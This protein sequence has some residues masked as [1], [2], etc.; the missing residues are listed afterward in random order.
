MLGRTLGHYRIIEKIGAGGMGVVYRAHDEQ[1]ERDVA[2]KILPANLISD[3]AAQKRFRKEALA[4]AKLNHSNIATVF[5]FA[6]ADG[7]FF[8]AMEYI[9]GT[10]LADKIHNAALPEKEVV[11]LGAQIAAALE[12][13]HEHKVIH[14]DLKPRNIVIT[15]AGQAKVLDFGLA[16][17]LIPESDVSTADA[18]SPTGVI[19]GTLPYMAPEQ[20]RAQSP[21]AR[22]DIYA[23]GVMLYEMASG[24]LPYSDKSA[25]ALITDILQ[26][27]PP[28]PST[29]K[30]GISPRLEEIILKCLEKDPENRYQSAKEL[31][32]DLRRLANPTAIYTP[33]AP[34][35][36]SWTAARPLLIYGSITFVAACILSVALYSGKWRVHLDKNST[37]GNIQSIA[38]LPLTNLSADPQQI[39]YA[40]GITEE[41]INALS[42]ISALR[43]ISL[44]SVMKYQGV[45]KSLADIARELHVD[46]IVQGSVQRSSDRVKISA[47]L[48][49]PRV[50]RNLWG[51]S[52]ESSLSDVL[53]LQSQVAQAVAGE[54]SVRL[55]PG[56]TASFSQK[57]TVNP[58]SYDAYLHARYLWN[59]RTPESLRQALA[60]FQHVTE[61]DPTSALGWSGL[62]DGYLLLANNGES[63]PRETMP[64]VEQAAQKALLLDDSLAEAHASLA[65]FEWQYKWDSA[66][67]EKEFERALALNP[68]YATARAWHGLYFDYSGSFDAAL[69]EFKLARQLDPLS[70]VILANEARSYYYA[71]NFDEAAARFEKLAADWPNNWIIHSLLGQT[72]LAR[73]DSDRA[74]RELLRARELSPSSVRNLGVLGDAY[75]RARKLDEARKIAAELEQLSRTRYVPQIYSALIYIGIG[76]KDRAFQ[77][78]EKSYDERS[79]WMTQLNCEPEF[80]P[81]RSDPRFQALAQRVAQG[82]P[83]EKH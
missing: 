43:V 52:Y 37:L 81:L 77:F 1:L 6:N 59:Q 20:L 65:V 24:R 13:A 73:G 33:R 18:M 25:A 15:Q 10:N 75:G 72:Y 69:A 44:A 26:S 70:Q 41:L 61:L 29:F 12:D 32:I 36:G 22:T 78:L 11:T 49:D 2:I 63:P 53:S 19:A 17:L 16:K 38:V 31:L 3:E 64:K 35:K 34:A 74:I 71:K 42:K 56:E 9:D 60:E 51:N 30:Q 55:T 67:A 62:A 8:L 39:Y 83:A 46:A 5:E 23:M 47:S 58:E 68:N 50:D 82:G 54:I 28:P 14:C 80:A 27:V 40:D 79:E 66:A 57:R 45:Q 76:D 7:V 48:V 21:D 4:L